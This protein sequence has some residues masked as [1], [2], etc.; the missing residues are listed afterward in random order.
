MSFLE[1]NNH[2]GRHNVEESAF[3]HCTALED[4][5]CDKLEIIKEGAFSCC[6]SLRSINLPSAEIVG[7]GAFNCCEHLTEV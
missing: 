7:R 3:Q 5:E 1:E 2:A 6:S 4:V